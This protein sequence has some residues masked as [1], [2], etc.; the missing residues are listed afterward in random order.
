MFTL[1]VELQIRHKYK[2]DRTGELMLNGKMVINVD[3]LE[4]LMSTT[5]LMILPGN[6]NIPNLTAATI[7]FFVDTNDQ[8]VEINIQ[9]SSLVDINVQFAIQH[10]CP[11]LKKVPM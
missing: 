1:K 7:H 10:W 4:W 2:Q 6:V 8:S 3:I 5:K 9:P 11:M